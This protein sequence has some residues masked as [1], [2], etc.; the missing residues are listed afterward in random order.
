MIS[1][2]GHVIFHQIGP[3]P[4]APYSILYG[5]FDPFNP[6]Q[7]QPVTVDGPAGTPCLR[8]S[9]ARHDWTNS[10]HAVWL[11][12]SEVLYSSKLIDGGNWDPPVSIATGGSLHDPSIEVYGDGAHAVWAAQTICGIKIFHF[13]RTIGQAGWSVPKE[14]SDCTAECGSPQM[15]AGKYCFWWQKNINPDNWEIY[16]ATW[17]GYEWSGRTNFSATSQHSVSPQVAFWPGMIGTQFYCFWT[18]DNAPPFQ[19]YFKTGWGPLSDFFSLDAGQVNPSPYTIHRGSYL[20]YGQHPEK[21][22]DTDESDLSYCFRH[23]DP[24]KMYLLR[25]SYYQETGSPIGL[26]VKVDG[27]TF[28]NVAVPNRSVI[29]GE[30]WLPAELFADSVIELSI[31]KRSGVLGA[32]GCLALCEA[33]P[34]GEGGPQSS[35]LTGLALPKEFSMGMGYPN[36]MTSDVRIA[37]ALPKASW[38]DL[39]VY[40]LSGQVVRRLVSEPSKAP[41]RYTVRWDGRNEIGH[42]VPA[43]VYFYRLKAEGFAETKK[44]VVVR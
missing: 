12:G 10:L 36:P 1:D 25:A 39:T 19:E 18:E 23:L 20:Q 29:R 33:E 11:K 2:R 4:D 8:P 27:A 6:S 21:T 14:V 32:L 44:L 7:F 43:G 38:V 9:L 3:D 31:Q 34:K 17:D 42:R 16:Y 22:V 41:G 30:A 26:E 28:A 5:M 13:F 24:R 35:G 15:A 40:N 37:Y